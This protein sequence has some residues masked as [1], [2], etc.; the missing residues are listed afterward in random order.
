MPKRH[1][2]AAKRRSSP[3]PAS[4]PEAAPIAPV[5]D[6][7]PRAS[8]SSI[9]PFVRELREFLDG[10][11]ATQKSQYYFGAVAALLATARLDAVEMAFMVPGHTKFESDIVCQLVAGLYNRSDCYNHGQL[12]EIVSKFATS[13]AYG[14]EQ[15]MDFR[16]A[17]P[18]LFASVSNIM[19]YRSFC[20]VA[21]D[22]AVDA[23]TELVGG[24][25]LPTHF[26]SVGPFGE[27]HHRER[28]FWHDGEVP[29]FGAAEGA[30]TVR[31]RG[32]FAGF[33]TATIGSANRI[34]AQGLSS[35][36]FTREIVRGQFSVSEPRLAAAVGEAAEASRLTAA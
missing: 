36:A 9:C 12:C 29:D 16:R 6:A 27:R 15:I 2:E 10:C 3:K 5:E 33:H 26:H 32:A 1:R 11:P 34:I 31:V 13:H 23:E 30:I 18:S 24:G 7:E 4:A 8:S 28:A 14:G 25:V 35:Y 17:T 22:G 19:S 20:F 21:D